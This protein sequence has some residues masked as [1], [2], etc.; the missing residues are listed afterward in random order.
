MLVKAHINPTIIA[1][2]AIR[3]NHVGSVR[4]ASVDGLQD[5]LGGVGHN[6]RVDVLAGL[7]QTKARTS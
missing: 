4:P 6:L 5:G 7:E 3:V 1:T 2:P